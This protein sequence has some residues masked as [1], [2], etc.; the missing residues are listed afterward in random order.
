VFP[1]FANLSGHRARLNDV[2]TAHLEHN[3][4]PV[5]RLTVIDY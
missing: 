4:A 3:Q 2:R 5:D 1:I